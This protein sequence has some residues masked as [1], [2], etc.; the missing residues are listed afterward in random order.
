MKLI[1]ALLLTINSVAFAQDEDEAATPEAP[2]CQEEL[3]DCAM[4]FQLA[5]GAVRAQQEVIT[6]QN[7]QISELEV[8]LKE[9]QVALDK[10]NAWYR[11]T[12]VMTP[13]GVILGI[14]FGAY[15]TK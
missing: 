1:L 4:G 7:E 8:M 10:K 3:A 5:V 11:D 14:V 15:V 12:S 6:E 13:I 9:N 2:A